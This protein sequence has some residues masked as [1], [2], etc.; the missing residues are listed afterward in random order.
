M[1]AAAQMPGVTR[2]FTSMT[3]FSIDAVARV[4]PTRIE[5]PTLSGM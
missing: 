5:A 1:I 2:L 4:G 3:L